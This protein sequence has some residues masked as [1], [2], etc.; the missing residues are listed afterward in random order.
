MAS[1]A[2][3]CRRFTRRG[4]AKVTTQ[5]QLYWPVHNIENIATNA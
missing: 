4:K 2:Q 5:W 1:R 3:N